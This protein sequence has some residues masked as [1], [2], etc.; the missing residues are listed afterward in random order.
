MAEFL[1]PVFQ[2]FLFGSMILFAFSAYKWRDR[3]YA[4]KGQFFLV[5]LALA[6]FGFFLL[7]GGVAASTLS[8]GSMLLMAGGA[9]M[10]LGAVVQTF[11]IYRFVNA[12]SSL[13]GGSN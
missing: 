9:V 10:F 8:K 4:L 12:G 6:V 2:L 3:L 5:S 7:S 13:A 11:A 1:V